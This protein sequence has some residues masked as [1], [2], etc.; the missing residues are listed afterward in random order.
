MVS[1]AIVVVA[2][3][4]TGQMGGTVAGFESYRYKKD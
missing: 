1:G 4:I 2:P 3:P